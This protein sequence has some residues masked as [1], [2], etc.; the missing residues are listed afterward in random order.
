MSFA[1]EL[2]DLVENDASGTNGSVETGGGK[3]PRTSPRE[4]GAAAPERAPRGPSWVLA[5]APQCQSLLH[6]Y[7]FDGANVDLCHCGNTEQL[8][9]RCAQ[10]RLDRIQER[11]VDAYEDAETRRRVFW[12][13]TCAALQRDL[14]STAPLSARSSSPPVPIPPR[15]PS[16]DYNVY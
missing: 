4:A 8:E 11:I 7:H 3:G 9:G 12:C 14:R 15:R 6:A 10:C 5:L 13:R 2:D 16:P 1:V